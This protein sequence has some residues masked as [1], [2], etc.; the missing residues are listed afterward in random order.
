MRALTL[1]A[2]VAALPMAAA[3]HDTTINYPDAPK[4]DVVD[5]MHGV[6]IAD[7]Y[8]WLEEDVRESERVADWVN[9]QNEVTFNYLE[10]IEGRDAIHARMSQLWDFTAY[11]TPDKAGGK[12]FFRQREEGQN[13][14]VLYVQDSLEGEPRVLL[15]PNT[16]SDDGT[17]ALGGY[18]PSEDGSKLLYTVQDGGTDWRT[19][20]VLDVES[21]EEQGATLEWLK[22]TNLAWAPDG[23][24]YYYARFPEPEEG[25]EFQNLNYDQK[26]YFHALGTEQSEDRLVYERPESPE[27]GFSPQ[28]S[29]N[30]EW[31]VVTASQGTDERYEIGLK[32]L[33]DPQSEIRW[34]VTGFENDYGLIGEDGEGRLYFRTDKDA[35][36]GRVVRMDPR[37]DAVSWEEVIPEGEFTLSGAE[38][39]GD[40]ILAHYIEDAKS[41][42]RLFELDGEAAG[43]V[44]L[45]GLGSASGFEGEYGDP[46]TFYSFH[47]FNRPD[48]IYRLDASAGESTEF[49]A[50]ELPFDPDDYEIAQVFYESKDGTR[51]PMFVMGRPDVLDQGPAPALLYGYGGFNIS[52]LPD[53]HPQF[54]TWAD[55]GGVFALANIRGGGEY[56]KDW[57]DA[58]RLDNKQNV[59]D[60]FAAG[61]QFLIDEAVTTSDQLGIHG[62]SNGGLLV[63]AVVNQ[64]PDLMAVG[65]PTVGVMDMLRFNQFTAG[66]YWTDD[67]GDPGDAEDFEV[68]RT[69]SPYH[70]ID[71][72]ADYPAI[73]ATTADTDDRVV[74]GHT[75]KYIAR[76]Q[77]DAQGG[78][79]EEGEQPILVRIETR[80]GHGSGKPKSQLIDEYTDQMAFLAHNTGLEIAAPVS[81]E[82]DGEAEDAH[83]GHSDASD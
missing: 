63:G 13:Q 62:R 33:T 74:P 48:T 77:Q 46:E 66:R 80:A 27:I 26:V 8:R 81:G 39:V 72:S 11:F 42:V 51:I 24:G 60:D 34:I 38:I 25:E 41:G 5:V 50:P 2:A 65:L 78:A 56:G 28:V 59:F 10:A 82:E 75:F 43:R 68:L 15:D 44:A 35:P 12:Y 73:L 40:K 6:E 36:M 23:S 16:W 54:L 4:G 61:A 71:D 45:P 79:A 37:A 53:F 18:W 9:A 55:M 69:Y 29:D 22:F 30:G 76:L 83:A 7:P 19:A 17:V 21:G 57:H 1:I 14:P 3:A 47:S 58:G 49:K 32:D 31:L 20:K 67:Y 64:H 70:N 52:Y